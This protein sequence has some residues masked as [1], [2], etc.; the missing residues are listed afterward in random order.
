MKL[1]LRAAPLPAAHEAAAERLV[2]LRAT[3]DTDEVRTLGERLHAEGGR[4]LMTAIAERADTLCQLRDDVSI[5]RD[6][7]RAWDGIGQRRR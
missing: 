6:V 3:L 1:V 7:E 5:M 4:P 2:E